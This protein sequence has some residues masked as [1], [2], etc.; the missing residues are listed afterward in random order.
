MPLTLDEKREY[1]ALLEAKRSRIAQRSLEAFA[2]SIEIPGTPIQEDGDEFYPDKVVPA[3]HHRLILDVLEKVDS[4]EIP[5]AMFFL[6]PG[7]AKTTYATVVFVPW[8]MGRHPNSNTIVAS[9]GSELA[10]KFSRKARSI[11]KSSE[12]QTIFGATLAGGN[13]AVDDW[14]MTN[15]ATYMAGGILSGITGNRADLLVIDD[16]VKGR[17]DADSETIRDKTWD[18]Y[19]ADLDTRLKPSGRQ[20]IIQCMTGDTLV[21]MAEGDEKPLRD[22]RSGDEIATYQNGRLSTSTV[23]NWASNGVDRV[24]RI[25]TT[26]GITVKA[27]ARHPFLVQ[28]DETLKWIRTRDLR[29]GQEIVRVN[30]GSGKASLVNRMGAKSLPDAEVIV[31]R[32]T[33]KSAGKHPKC[34]RQPP[35]TSD[36]ILDEVA[37]VQECGSE[38]VFDIQVDET[39]NFIANG[40]VSHNTR[41]H[42][43]DLSGRI[44]PEDYDGASGWVTSRFGQKWYVVNIPA[45]CE[46]EDDPLGRAIGEWL[47]LDQENW[48]TIDWWENKKLAQTPRNWSALYQQ[49]PAPEEGAYFLNEWIKWFDKPPE[50]SLL[51]IYGA[52]DYAVSDGE[53]DW[54]V[55]L[56]V[57]VDHADNIYLLDMWR[58]KTATDV[59]IN[60]FCDLILKWKPIEWAEE[61]GQIKRSVGPFI[62]KRQRERKAY[63][64]RR[65]FST[66]GDK[67]MRAQSIRGRMAMGNVLF[68]RNAP[69]VKDFIAE[70]LT[71]P[72]GRHDDQV[73]AFGLIGRM[74]DRMGKGKT[75]PPKPEGIKGIEAVTLDRLFQDRETEQRKWF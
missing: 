1:L 64:H 21:R 71:F 10:K 28:Q 73:D 54:T 62:V 57:G 2:R 4:G 65:Q 58:Q 36:F 33:T 8:F 14:S 67:E 7:S 15:G 19:L 3:A 12:Y 44:L 24:L 42:E 46:R 55:H 59:W 61:A 43:D 50:R 68:P 47:W 5:R 48:I 11:V 75:K 74:L 39:E 69:W 49:R 63:T 27:N 32:I 9:Y 60:S 52:S 37:S 35:L 38:E 53:G 25:R 23:R 13:T 31:P 30:G 26:S 56:V 18:A 66:V 72:A 22:I 20:V 29:Q 41:W 34:W 45:Q 16:P 17:E 6:P 40:L 70:L 51:K